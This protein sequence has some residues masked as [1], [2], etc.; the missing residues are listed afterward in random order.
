MFRL[1]L[2]RLLLAIPTLIA[3]VTI[4]FLIVR[5]IP[6][7]PATAVLGDRAS[8]EAVEQLRQ[9]M[10]LNDPIW[11]QYLDY[12]TGLARGDLGDALITRKPAWEQISFVLPYTLE[13]TFAAVLIALL[14]GIPGGI[15]TAV[16]RNTWVDYLG[17]VL[18]LAGLSAPAF[19]VGL[20]LMF[21]FSAKAGW[22][23]A[24]GAG[25]FSEPGK[26][27]HSLVLPAITLGLVETA[28]VTRMTR[29]VMLD[30][31]SNDYVRTAR[32]KGLAQRVVLM[33]HALRPAL[34]PIIA[35]TGIFTIGLIGSS[36]LTETVFARP[37]L[38]KLMVGATKQRDYNLLQAIMVVYALI[39]VA[40]NI[41]VDIIYTWADPRVRY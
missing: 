2:K 22:F 40:I 15:I 12:M 18:S 9:Q 8:E 32:A 38:G 25:T 17:R 34:V 14:V 4:I 21:F 5:V 36:V 37:G 27:L 16:R 35:L 6:G 41:V 3:V 33:R 19:Y 1:I 28:Y 20:L 30:V 11:K 26:N 23:P 29:S 24:V 7:D 39:I 31:L 13:L 10:G